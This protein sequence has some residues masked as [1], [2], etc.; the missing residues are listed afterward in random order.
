MA[1]RHVSERSTMSSPC[2][3]RLPSLVLV[4]GSVSWVRFCNATESMQSKVDPNA[5]CV[6]VELPM[7]QINCHVICINAQRL[8][9][10]HRVEN[11]AAADKT[12]GAQQYPLFT[13]RTV[14][15]CTKSQVRQQ[16]Q[17]NAAELSHDIKG[18]G[19]Q[20]CRVTTFKCVL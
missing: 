9:V 11:F 2:C 4:E 17:D 5:S 1:D 18:C 15:W 16:Q 13:V 19:R 6:K 14:P 12:K 20:P 8:A 10:R 7:P 3:C